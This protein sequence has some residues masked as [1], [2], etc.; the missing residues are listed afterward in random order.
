MKNDFKKLTRCAGKCLT[1]FKNFWSSRPTLCRISSKF[2]RKIFG[3]KNWSVTLA[4][5]RDV[6]FV[7]KSETEMAESLSKMARRC[8][9]NNF[10]AKFKSAT[11]SSV[12]VLLTI[13]VELNKEGMQ[14]PGFCGSEKKI[15]WYCSSKEGSTI[16]F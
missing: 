15:K 2:I 4:E 3:A 6:A 10:G 9:G 7:T 5:S 13:S 16:L 11:M 12:R 14:F 8:D 1:F